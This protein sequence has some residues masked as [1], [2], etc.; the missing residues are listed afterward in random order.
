MELGCAS[1]DKELLPRLDSREL[2]EWMVYAELEPFGPQAVNLNSATIASILYN[3]NRPKHSRA[4]SV[5]EIALGDF[6]GEKEKQTQEEL[7]IAFKD[8]ARTHNAGIKKRK[9]KKNG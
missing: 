3:A 2:S 4:K 9:G 8:F 7:V 6:S 5:I 1:V